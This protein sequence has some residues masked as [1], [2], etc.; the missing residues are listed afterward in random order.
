MTNFTRN[1]LVR[2]HLMKVWLHWRSTRRG[3][4][5]PLLTTKHELSIKPECGGAWKSAWSHCDKLLTSHQRLAEEARGGGW[6]LTLPPTVHTGPRASQRK[7]S[8][9]FAIY[10]HA[11]IN[12]CAARR[13]ENHS[14]K[15]ERTTAEGNKKKKTQ[16]EMTLEMIDKYSPGEIFRVLTTW[17]QQ[18]RLPRLFITY[19]SVNYLVM[20]VS[21]FYETI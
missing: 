12:I 19:I 13:A 15:G 17:R 9:L 4:W 3:F 6:S 10:L 18:I 14:A 20:K 5:I 1:Y 21:R 16:V 8:R 7:C 11:I 2:R